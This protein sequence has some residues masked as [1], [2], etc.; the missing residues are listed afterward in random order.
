M[1]LKRSYHL[2]YVFHSA[3]VITDICRHIP[4][5][6]LLWLYSIN[7]TGWVIDNASDNSG[8]NKEN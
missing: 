4:L 7:S 6:V 1:L 5:G 2:A 3:S 8:D